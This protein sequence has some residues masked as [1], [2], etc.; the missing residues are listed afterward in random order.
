[1]KCIQ[2]GKCCYDTEML[3]SEEDIKRIE[4]LGYARNEFLEI[5]NNGFAK[6]KNRGGHCVFLNPETNLCKI[7]SE[8]PLGC[9]LYP[10]IYDLNKKKCIVD[11]FCPMWYTVSKKEKTHACRSI[12]RLIEKIFNEQKRRYADFK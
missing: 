4:K 12:K 5:D 6:L 7:Y 1:M 10:V 11:K 9:R 3:L 8:R 2:E